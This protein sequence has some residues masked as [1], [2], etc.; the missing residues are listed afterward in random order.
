MDKRGTDKMI[1]VYWFFILFL[2]TAAIVYMVSAFY[3]APYDVRNLEA[4]ILTNRVADCIYRGGEINGELF[5]GEFNSGFEEEFFS[6]CGLNF[7]GESRWNGEIQYYVGFDIYRV[8]DVQNSVYSLAEGNLNLLSN[9]EIEDEDYDK[10][11]KCVNRRMYVAFEG[12]QFLVDI[13]GVVRKTEK[14]VK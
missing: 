10:L 6:V 12:Q 13:T 14:N 4:N 8:N 11:A 1:S 5:D 3:S 7:E 2:V 9:C